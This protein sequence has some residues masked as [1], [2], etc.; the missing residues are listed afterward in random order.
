MPVVPVQYLVAMK[1]VSGEPKDD[2][3]AKRLLEHVKLNYAATRRIVRKHL[4]PATADRLDV[5][6]REAGRPEVPRRRKYE[7]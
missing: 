2:R 3:D 5:F 6:A 7:S 1:M 4:G